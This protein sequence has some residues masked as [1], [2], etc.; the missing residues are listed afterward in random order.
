MPE[1]REEAD[2]AAIRDV[3]QA[4]T[5][6]V[7]TR[8]ATRCS[9][10]RATFDHAPPLRHTDAEA[11]RNLWART[12]ASFDPPVE[13]DL[14]DI[15]IDAAGDVTFSWCLSRFGGARTTNRLRS[16]FGFRRVDG[17][18]K[19]VHEHVK[20]RSDSPSGSMPHLRV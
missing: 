11:L 8:D 19:L 13:Y 20:V 18:W 14:E 10:D 3:M 7:R 4:I 16:T 6:A 5:E 9:P 15:S 1:H 2:E 17:R 12:L